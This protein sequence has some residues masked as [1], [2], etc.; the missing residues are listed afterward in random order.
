VL[1]FGAVLLLVC[2]AQIKPKLPAKTA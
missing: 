1:T 2:L